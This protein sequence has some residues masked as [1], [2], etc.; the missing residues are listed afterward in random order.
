KP[1]YQEEE[2]L[3]RVL[4]KQDEMVQAAA[5]REQALIKQLDDQIANFKKPVRFKKQEAAIYADVNAA[6]I[7]KKGVVLDQAGMQKF[8][9]KLRAGA[10][11]E[12]QQS[13]MQ[14]LPD[15]L[16]ANLANQGKVKSVVEKTAPEMM[17]IED[18]LEALRGGRKKSFIQ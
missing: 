12:G 11:R 13:A 10:S 9:D 3:R 2:V 17:E 5:K 15:L 1:L 14:Q 7:T 16:E 6:K 4:S 8:R 18:A